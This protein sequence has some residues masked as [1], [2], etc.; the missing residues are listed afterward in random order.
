MDDLLAKLRAAKPEARDQRD[1]RRRARLK[2]RHAV[3]VASG[4]TMPEMDELVQTPAL[5]EGLLSPVKSEGGLS[6][7]GTDENPPLSAG[8]SVPEEEDVADQAEKLLQGLGGASG[9]EEEGEE[10]VPIPRESIRVSRRRK[11]GAEDERSRRRRRRQQAMSASEASLENHSRDSH[12]IREEDGGNEQEINGEEEDGGETPKPP[13]HDG[14]NVYRERNSD[15]PVT[16][17]SPP[18]PELTPTKGRDAGLPTP[19]GD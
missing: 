12:T 15:T 16:I 6:S 17:I 9:G 18:S 10:R 3:R 13:Q 4:Q 7:S 1:R 8:L 11:E 14:G 19:P 2:D 5:E